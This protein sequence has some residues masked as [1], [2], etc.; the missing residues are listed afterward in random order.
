MSYTKFSI[1]HT[2]KFSA[3]YSSLSRNYYI[4]SIVMPAHYSIHQQFLRTTVYYIIITVLVEATGS[5]QGIT[6]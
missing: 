2:I 1:F 5:P 6:P 3:M 4:G